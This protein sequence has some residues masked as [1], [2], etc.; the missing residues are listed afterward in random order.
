[1]HDCV[2]HDPLRMSV[3]ATCLNFENQRHFE[4]D[5]D[6]ISTK[7]KAEIAPIVSYLH[8]LLSGKCY[9]FLMLKFYANLRSNQAFIYMHDYGG[10][11]VNIQR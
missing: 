11:H 6:V 3:S 7:I 1:M 2:R 4:W 8:D 10:I 9:T 5:F